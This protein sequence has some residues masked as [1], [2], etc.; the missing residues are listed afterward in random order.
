[1]REDE[2]LLKSLGALYRFGDGWQ[3]WGHYGEGFK[4]P[5][6]Q[7]L[8]TSVPD[9][10]FDLIPAPDLEPEKVKSIEAGLRRETERGFFGITAFSADYD[11]FI[12]EFYNPPGTSDYTY[13][14][15]SSV[16]IWW[17]ELEG[18]YEIS[19]TLRLTASA[20]WQKGN[21]R[22][23][24]DAAKTPTR[25][26]PLSG[27]IAISWDTPQ[28]GL[29]VDLVGLFASSVKYVESEDKFKPAGYGV[30]D[31]FARWEFAENAVLSLG[32]RNLFD[33]RYFEASAAT[34]DRVTSSAV[35][36]SNPIELQTGAG[37]AFTASL[38]Y[39]F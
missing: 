37:R 5:T 8:Y 7:Q 32:V 16:H 33:K 3:I 17:L 39:K 27:T 9:A 2:T 30:I 12:E 34:Y 24:P 18:R 22:T 36:N 19:D 1:M 29:T 13:R 14:N 23:G 20:A 21:Q 38:D 10:F 11:N 4:M 15:L 26:P 6:A 28:P 35:A 31:A 25:V